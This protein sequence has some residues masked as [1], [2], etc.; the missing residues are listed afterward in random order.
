MNQQQ[1]YTVKEFAEAYNI[2][3]D[4][5]YSVF[6]RDDFPAFRNGNRFLVLRAA[7]HD[8]FVAESYKTK[9]KVA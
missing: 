5:A 4:A 1:T 7:A 6:K 9:G 8:Y 3:R 2:G